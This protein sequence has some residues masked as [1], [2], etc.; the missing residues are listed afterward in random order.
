MTI[1]ELVTKAHE[2]AKRKGFYDQEKNIGEALML[3]V[4]ELSEALEADRHG[5]RSKKT[6]ELVN[7]RVVDCTGLKPHDFACEVKDTLEDELADA[8]IRIAD[9]A[10]YLGI[11]LEAHVIAKM[12]Y[13]ETRP[14]KHGKAY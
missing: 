8:A 6:W 4:S 10:G 3:I 5:R 13:N 12:A 9:L 1:T 2:N 11:D 7:H 14:Q